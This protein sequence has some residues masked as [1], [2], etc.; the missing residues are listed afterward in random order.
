M[1][2]S[3]LLAGLAGSIQMLGVQ[4]FYATGI[5]NKVGFDSITVALL[6]RSSPIGIML[7]AL[8]FGVLRAG[9]NLM[10]LRTQ[11]QVPIEVIDVIQALIILF[12]AAD[13][14][15]R[16]VFRLRTA[17]GAIE[18]EVRTVTASWGEQV[19]R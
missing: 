2:L 18:G 1:T 14:I 15:V 13:I 19:A 7:S 12:L 5:S 10:Q 3:G 6:G 8:L 11:N 9:Q 17:K 4:G 16:R